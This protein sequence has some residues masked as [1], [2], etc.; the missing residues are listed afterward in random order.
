MNALHSG[1]LG[2]I[3]YFLPVLR[4][5]GNDNRIYYIDRPVTKKI[6]PRIPLIHPLVEAQDYIVESAAYHKQHVD[7]D[8]STF[9]RFHQ[10]S[11]TL[12]EAQAMHAGIA[13]PKYKPWL[14][15]GEMNHGFRVVVARS[16]R[17]NNNKFPWAQLMAK[18]SSGEVGFVGLQHEFDSFRKNYCGYIKKIP[19]ANL[20]DVACA[21]NSAELFIGNQ[22]SPLAVAVGLGKKRI[23][24]VCT[25]VPDC[26]YPG[27]AV[28]CWDGHLVYEDEDLFVDP[29]EELEVPESLV[30]PGGWRA[31]DGK[32]YLTIRQAVQKQMQLDGIGP[33]EAKTKVIK[34][35]KKEVDRSFFMGAEP[36]D[37]YHRVDKA[38]ETMKKVLQ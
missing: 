2:D 5:F 14:K 31:G 36:D 27:D 20:W 37:L 28:H 16:P 6:T 1:D 8:A 11:R 24:E 22:S 23:V 25:R 38:L 29:Y 30:P 15:A 10:P 34:R 7:H 18:F 26:I 17:Y 35:T 19:T 33:V 3:I 4:E 32:G 13:C 12:M 9:R 21:I